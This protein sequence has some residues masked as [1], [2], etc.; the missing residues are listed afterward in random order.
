VV[1]ATFGASVSCSVPVRAL[2]FFGRIRGCARSLR[3][4]HIARPLYRDLQARLRSMEKI[5]GF[6]ED[7]LKQAEHSPRKADQIK[8]AEAAMHLLDKR[9]VVLHHKRYP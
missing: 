3:V 2:F 9:L 1:I 5:F 8:L 7:T 4:F 6:Q